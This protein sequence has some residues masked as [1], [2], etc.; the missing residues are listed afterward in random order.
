[1]PRFPLRSLLA[2]CAW[3]LAWAAATTP[4][5]A[6][7]VITNVKDAKGQPVADAV[8]SLVALDPSVPVP[9]V[10]AADPVVI[11]QQGQEFAPYVNVIAVGTRVS[12]PNHDK[13][14]HQVYSLSKTKP[15]E[16]PLYGPGVT[17]TVLF[18]RPGVV[19]LGCNIHDWMAAYI[20]V[21]ETPW[22]AKTAVAGVASVTNLAPGR[23]RLDV[24]HPRLAGESH[25][26]IVV[27]SGDAPPQ[28][29]SITLKADRRIRRA[30]EG[31]GGGYK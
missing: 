9:A 13:I 16:L 31:A 19:S 5:A 7:T 18:D 12:F 11:T 3:A 10:A 20:V 29:I 15:F 8:V 17:Q 14:H 26:E 27:P 30:P 24:W 6:G 23:Y 25:R 22:S 21:L 4:L 1:M 2:V 28:T